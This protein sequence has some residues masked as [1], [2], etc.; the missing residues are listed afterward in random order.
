MIFVTCTMEIAQ[1]VLISRFVLNLNFFNIKGC[2]YCN[3]FQQCL[4]TT[5]MGPA[6]KNC[7]CEVWMNE[8]RQCIEGI[9][10]EL[11]HKHILIEP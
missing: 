4:P 6:I 1:N 5:G 8:P 3:D 10:F 2:G 11:K 7:H 9:L